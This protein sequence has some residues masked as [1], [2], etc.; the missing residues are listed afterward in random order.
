MHILIVN[1]DGILAKGIQELA[2][3][4]S[5]DHN[6][7]VIAP[8]EQQ[9]AKSHAITIFKPLVVKSF[10]MKDINGRAFSVSGTPAD[11]VRAGIEGIIKEEEIDIVVSGIN[12]GVNLGM[13]VL[14]SGTV[15]AAIE[16]SL[17]NL[18]SIA[19]SA[20]IDKYGNGRF[21]LGATYVRG[22]IRDKFDKIK[23][24]GKVININIPKLPDGEIKGVMPCRIGQVIYDY[25]TDDVDEEGQ[26]I[27]Q[28]VSRKNPEEMIK[29]TDRYY[30]KK[31]YITV[32]PLQY[33]F[34]CFEGL[35]D[36]RGWI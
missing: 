18:P 9:S 20:E 25:Y 15:S 21:D 4:L 36:I 23:D 19:I 17:Y 33:D 6:V 14:Y 10:D 12:Y 35:E 26:R 16:A 28:P 13:D 2:R 34:T 7:T 5:K 22:L 32:T 1:D 8:D 31:G 29:D 11:C 30:I 27:V 3:E 24:F